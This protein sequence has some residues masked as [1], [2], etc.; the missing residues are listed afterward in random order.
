MGRLLSVSRAARLAGVSR[1]AIQKQIQAGE[2]PTFEGMVQLSDLQQ[3]YPDLSLEDSTMLERV[4]RI[5]RDAVNKYQ[6]DELPNEALLAQEV[7]RLRTKLADAEVEIAAFH[8]LV[9]SLK[10]RLTALQQDCDLQQK[11]LLQAILAWMQGQM[12]KRF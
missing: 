7:N 10:D 1:A 9:S 6:Q 8:A 2:L 11:R 12:D 4:H 5:Q 3:E